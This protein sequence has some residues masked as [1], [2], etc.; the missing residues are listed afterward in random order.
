MG[1]PVARLIVGSNRNDIL[2]RFLESNDMSMTPVEPSLSPSM[3]IQVSSN[4][5]RLLFEL[6]ERDPVALTKTMHAFRETGHMPVS[7]AV[8]H[9]ARGVLHGFRLDDAG[10]AAEIR[11]LHAESGYL[12]DPHTIIGVAAARAHAPGQGIPTVAMATAHPAKFPDAMERATGVRP[13]LPPRMAD[14]FEREERFT[15]MPNDLKAVQARVRALVGRN[16][17]SIETEG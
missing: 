3:D 4:F 1:L 8:W 6:L 5:E 9:R 14:L 7:D 13:P 12:A 17:A 11:R 16:A 15:V 2:Y 10:T